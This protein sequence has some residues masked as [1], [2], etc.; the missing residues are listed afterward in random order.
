M[1]AQAQ[2]IPFAPATN[3]ESILAA[4]IAAQVKAIVVE[5]LEAAPRIPQILFTVSEAAIYL[6]RTRKAVEHVIADKK[7]PIVRDGR[8]IQL[9]RTDLDRW[10]DQNKY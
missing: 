7:L 4:Q 5:Q 10:I 9:H 6:G 3:L 1:A 2:V 8:K